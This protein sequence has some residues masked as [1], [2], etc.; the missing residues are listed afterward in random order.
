MALE[1]LYFPPES[2]NVDTYVIDI[3]LPLLVLRP[4]RALSWTSR[5]CWAG[6]ATC[7]QSCRTCS[8]TDP[9][10]HN[11]YTFV[12]CMAQPIHICQ[13]HYVFT[14]L[15]SIKIAQVHD[16]TDCYERLFHPINFSINNKKINLIHV[17]KFHLK[18]AFWT[19]YFI[20]SFASP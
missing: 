3:F 17:C 13:M 11:K 2:G 8:W 19:K 12:N 7:W 4:W 18:M 1:K 6:W 9:I 10:R 15:L 5:I 14:R 16:V 20:N